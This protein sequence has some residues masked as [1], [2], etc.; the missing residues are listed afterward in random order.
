MKI[1]SYIP[2]KKPRSFTHEKYGP[3]FIVGH[4]ELLKLFEY[5]GGTEQ[6]WLPRNSKIKKSFKNQQ[7]KRSRLDKTLWN[8]LVMP[9][10]H[11]DP[12][13]P[14]AIAVSIPTYDFDAEWQEM[15]IHELRY[16][17]SAFQIV[18]IPIIVEEL[19]K[20]VGGKKRDNEI[21]ERHFDM[22]IA[23]VAP[24]ADEDRREA[25]RQVIVYVKP[26]KK[27]AGVYEISYQA[28]KRQCSRVQTKL[29]AIPESKPDDNE[30]QET[31]DNLGGHRGRAASK[32]GVD[33]A[34]VQRYLADRAAEASQEAEDVEV[35]DIE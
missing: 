27:I 13:P 24:D 29:A 22:Y 34:T 7:Y 28:F 23:E 17:A 4:S 8:P 31:L 10:P 26:V 6:V 5:D 21:T 2:A 16:P 9:C 11:G 12:L 19:P 33:R 18:S 25:L 14:D 20:N 15:M 30:I 3:G 1:R 32:L 35:G